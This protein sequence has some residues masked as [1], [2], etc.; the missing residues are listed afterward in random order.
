V[1]KTCLPTTSLYQC[2]CDSAIT[3][4]KAL[5]DNDPAENC[6]SRDDVYASNDNPALGD[7]NCDDGSAYDDDID[8]GDNPVTC[9]SDDDDK[10]LQHHM[11]KTTVD[12]NKSQGVSSK[13]TIKIT[14]NNDIIHICINVIIIMLSLL[15]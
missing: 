15:L 13:R 6:D 4:V 10:M 11:A 2:G 9:A 14:G 1:K 8:K 3:I 5:R 12:R 7:A